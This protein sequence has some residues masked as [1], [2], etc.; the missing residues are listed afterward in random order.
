MKAI[1]DQVLGPTNRSQHLSLDELCQK[2]A[3]FILRMS[4][5]LCKYGD[6]NLEFRKHLST[7][8]EELKATALFTRIC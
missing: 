5:Y 3:G 8:V 4:A 1:A 2:V 6:A 7:H